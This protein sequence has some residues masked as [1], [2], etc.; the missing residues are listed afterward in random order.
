MDSFD[1]DYY[2]IKDRLLTTAGLTMKEAGERLHN[3][4]RREFREMSGV[5][6]W[7][8]ARRNYEEFFCKVEQKEEI[9]LAATASWVRG[10]GTDTCNQFLDCRSPGTKREFLDAL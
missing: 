7:R 8:I 6:L 2:A 1:D 4:P 10:H 5:D 3:K 9:I